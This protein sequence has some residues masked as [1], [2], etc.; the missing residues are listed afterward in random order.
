MVEQHVAPRTR[1]AVHAV[2]RSQRVSRDETLALRCQTNWLKTA[3]QCRQ[4]EGALSEAR[5]ACALAQALRVRARP[6]KLFAE[7]T[8]QIRGS[9]MHALVRVDGSAVAPS[10]WL[11]LA[12]LDERT[13][14]TAFDPLATT[15]S[16]SRSCERLLDL[17]LLEP[18]L[19]R[20]HTTRMLRVL[21]TSDASAFS[22]AV[23]HRGW[24]D[25]L[26][27]IGDLD[28]GSVELVEAALS[29]VTA[30]EVL[31]DLSLLTFI[32]TRALS[33][34]RDARR[35]LTASGRFV[36][37]S[38]ATGIARRLFE[39]TRTDELLD[40]GLR[41]QTREPNATARILPFRSTDNRR[42]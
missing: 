3:D 2:E 27:L 5:D 4:S 39:L 29:E 18:D 40:D 32:D 1:R 31:I 38:G 37:V 13:S 14:G 34:L 35:R 8:G 28:V 24:F 23:D 6:L 20:G 16:L 21:G 33:P 42:R 22:V 26:R 25:V 12:C 30:H 36:L 17:E 11:L 15:V 9:V 10:P 19:G 7:L 41:P